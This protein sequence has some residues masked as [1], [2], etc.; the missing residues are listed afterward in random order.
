MTSLPER[1][2]RTETIAAGHAGRVMLIETA[3]GR[4]LWE[5]V[6]AET[7]GASACDGEP[8][9]VRLTDTCVIAGTMGHVFALRLDDGSL[10]WHIDRRS[11]GA[12][13]TS[14]AVGSAPLKHG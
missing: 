6:L 4:L 7:P 12:G 14:L 13:T 8:V 1:L 9:A 2:H 11:R 10:L 5:T 3:T